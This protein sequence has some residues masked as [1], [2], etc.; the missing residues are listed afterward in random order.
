MEDV[1]SK[2][3][4]GRESNAICPKPTNQMVKIHKGLCKAASPLVL[5]M[6]TEKIG[7]NKFLNS[8]KM[9]RFDSP[10]CP[11]RRAVQSAKHLLVECQ[12]YTGKK[13]STC[14]VDRRKAAFRMISWEEMLTQP[15]FTK[16]AAQ[17]MK[18]LGLL[19]QF[20]SRT[21]D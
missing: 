2:R 17:C 15:K 6:R 13:N 20:N 11:C 1:W 4:T 8:R 7:L 19:D 14:E 16:K 12:A 5:K 21:F 10:E 18:S 3:K 9:P